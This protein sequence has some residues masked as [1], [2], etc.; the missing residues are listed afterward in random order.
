MNNNSISTLVFVDSNVAESQTFIDAVNPN[1]EVILLDANR[2]GIEQI[3]EILANYNNLDSIQIV[4]HGDTAS[5]QLG[6]SSLNSNNFSSYQDRLSQWGDALTENGDL[7]LLGCNVAEGE[8][9]RSFINRLSE[10]TQADIAASEDLTGNS[11]LDGDWILEATTGSIEAPSAFQVEAIANYQGTLANVSEVEANNSISNPQYISASSFTNESNGD[12]QNSSGNNISQTYDHASVIGTG[13]GTFDYYSFSANAGKEFIFDIDNNNFDTELFLYDTNGNLIKNNDDSI[14]TGHSG[15]DRASFITHTFASAGTY[16]IGVAKY[17]SS[18]DSGGITG[19]TPSGGDSY[20]LNISSSQVPTFTVTNNNDSGPGSLRQAI[21]DAENNNNG[22][23]KDII[24]LSSLSS[25]DEDTIR[26]NSSLPIIEESVEIRGDGVQIWGRDTHQIFTVDGENND[27]QINLIGFRAVGGRAKGGDGYTGGG[28]GLGAGGALF[29]NQGRVVVDNV[30]FDYNGAI[31]GNSDWSYNGGFTESDGSA[32]GSG[33]RFNVNSSSTSISDVYSFD[34][35]PFFGGF[36][37]FGGTRNGDDGNPGGNGFGGSFGVGGGAGG[38]GGGAFD[39]IAAYDPE[40]RG[41]DGGNGGIGG[42]GAGGGAGGGGGRDYDFYSGDE[43]GNGGSGASGGTHGGSGTQGFNTRNTGTGGGGA[44]LG[45]AIFVNSDADLVL[46]NSSFE[47]NFVTGG[48]G[49]NFSSALGGN[50]Y[51]RDGATVSKFNTS[52]NNSYG[53]ISNFPLPNVSIQINSNKT[54]LAESSS[55]SSSFTI[56]LDK[57]FPLDLI[58]NYELSGTATNGTD[59]SNLSGSTTIPAGITSASIDLNVINDTNLEAP[60]TIV[61]TLKNGDNYNFNNSSVNY[62]ITDDDSISLTGT[63]NATEGSKNGLF[64][65]DWDGTAPSNSNLKFKITG[66]TADPK[67]DYR[68]LDPNSEDKALSPN[69]DGNYVLDISNESSVTVK[70]DA[71]GVVNGIP[72]YDDNIADPNETVEITL[73]QKVTLNSSERDIDS[74]TATVSIIDNDEP[75]II[76]LSTETSPQESEEKTGIFNLDLSSEVLANGEPASGA[77]V[78]YSISDTADNPEDYSLFLNIDGTRS[79]LSSTSG[80]FEIPIGKDASSSITIEVEPNDDKIADPNET[81]TLNLSSGSGY[82]LG[83]TTSATLTIQDDDIIPNATISSNSV[84]AEEGGVLNFTVNLDNPALAGGASVNYTVAGTA[85]EGTDFD[86]LN[87]TVTILEGEIEATVSIATTEDF[88]AEGTET[89]AISLDSG[90]GYN[91]TISDRSVTLDITDNDT[92]G[93]TITPERDNTSEAGGQAVFNAV[94]TSEPTAD[95]NLNLVSDDTTEGTVNTSSLVFNSNNWN[96]AQS[97]T[98]TGADDTEDDGDT[99]YNVTT[100]GVSSD[101]NYNGINVADVPLINIDND[102]FGV[103]VTAS[104][105]STNTSEAGTIDSY[106]IALSKTPGG[107]VEI[108]ITADGETQVSTDGVNFSNS[109]VVTLGDTT[110][111]TITVKATDDSVVEGTHSSTISHQISG[112]VIDSRYGTDLAIADITVQISDN[113]FPTVNI[114][115]TNDANEENLVAGQYNLVLSDPTPTEITVNYEVNNSSTAG[116][117]DYQPLSG[118]VSIPQGGTSATIN[119]IPT[120]DSIAETAETVVINLTGGTGYEL[121]ATTIGT[122]AIDDDDFAEVLITESGSQ[123]ELREGKT[124]DTYTLKLNSQPISDVTIS[125]AT[126]TNQINSI[127]SVT[128]TPDDWQTEQTV[129]VTSVDDN[130]V[131]GDRSSNIAHTATSSDANYDGIA[132]NSV[133]A[134]ITENDVAGIVVTNANNL[135]VT[136]GDTVSYSIAL[137]TQPLADVTLSFGTSNDLQS[138]TPLTFTPSNWNRSQTVTLSA[139]IDNEVESTEIQNITHSLTST[140]AVYNGLAVEDVA[141]AINEFTFDPTETA[142]GL[143][144]SLDSMQDSIDAQFTSIELP[145]I[146]SLDNLAP[147]LIGN[148]KNTLINAIQTAGSLDSDA[149]A[150]LIESKIESALGLDV[151]VNTDLSADE[152]TFDLTIAKEYNLASIGLDA[153][154]GL[155]GLGIEVE[156]SADLTF[157]YEFGLGFGISQEFGFFVDTDKTGFEA[158]VS[159][160]LSDN[161]NAKGSLGFLAIDIEND[162]DSPTAASVTFELGINDTDNSQGIKIFDANGDRQLDDNEPN[163]NVATNGTSDDLTPQANDPLDTNNNGAYDEEQFNRNEGVYDT[164]T[165]KISGTRRDVYFFDRDRDGRLDTAEPFIVYNDNNSNDR[166]DDGELSNTQVDNNNQFKLKKTTT[167]SPKLYFDK[168]NNN[169]LDAA[170]EVDRKFDKNNDLLLNPDENIAGE[171]AFEQGLGIAYLDQNNNGQLDS[172]EPFVNSAFDALSVDEEKVLNILTDS[173]SGTTYIDLDGDG[174]LGDDDPEADSSDADTTFLDLNDNQEYDEDDIDVVTDE[175]TGERFLDFDG[176]NFADD[177]ELKSDSEDDP[178]ELDDDVISTTTV[179]GEEISYLDKDLQPGLSDDD[180]KILIVDGVR[181]L[182]LDGDGEAGDSEPQAK[183]NNDFSELDRTQPGTYVEVLDDGDRL[184]LSEIGNSSLG[185]LFDISLAANANLGLSA[186]TSIE[187]DTAF[188]SIAFDLAGEFP[189]LSYEDGEVTGPQKPTIAFNDVELDLGSFLTDFAKPV[190][191][192]VNEIIDPF[193]PIVEF[194]N[195]DTKLLSEIGIDSLFD[196]N[197]DGKVNVLELAIKIAEL[198][199]KKPNA[200]YIKFFDSVVEISEL[201]ENLNALAE[202]GDNIIIDLGSYELGSSFDPSDS[203]ADATTAETDTTESAPSLDRQLNSSPTT[204]AKTTQKNITKNLTASGG[205]FEIPLLTNPSTAIDLLLGKDVPLFTYDMPALEVGFEIEKTFPIWGPIGGL[206]EGNFNVAVDL[207]FGFDTYGFR[208]WQEVTDFEPLESYRVLDGFY[209]SDRENADG[210]GADVDELTASATIAAGAGIDVKVVSG[211]VKGGLE[212][213]IGIDLVDGGEVNGSDDGRLRASEVIDRIATPWELFQLSGQVNAF[214]AAEVKAGLTT[215][216]EKRFATFQLAE[217]SVGPKG[218]SAS[219][220]FDGTIAGGKVFFDADFDLEHDASEP[221]T[222]TSAD[223]S[224]DLEIPLYQYDLNTNGEIDPDEGKVVIVDG[225][226]TSTGLP[227]TAPIITT[228]DATVATPLTSLAT[229]VAEPDFAASQTEVIDRFSLAANTNL[230]NYEATSADLGLFVTQTKLQNLLILATQKISTTAFIGETINGNNVLAQNGSIYLDNNN[231]QQL[232]EDDLEISLTEEGAR[233]FDL[234]GNEALDNGELSSPI[235]EADIATAII[236][237]IVTRVNNGTTPN[238]NDT[239]T[240]E[241]IISEA[242]TSP[243]VKDANTTLDAA[244]I[245]ALAAIIIEKN[246]TID[247]ILNS[248]FLSETQQRQQI[249]SQWTFID[250][251]NNEALDSSEPYSLVNDDGTNDLDITPFDANNN[252]ELDRRVTVTGNSPEWVFFDSNANGTFDESEPFSVVR[253]SGD[254]DLEID[255]LD[256]NDNGVQDNNEPFVITNTFGTTQIPITSFDTNTD[257]VL[258]PDE[259]ANIIVDGTALTQWSYVDSNNNGEFDR[260]EL[261]SVIYNDGSDELDPYVEGR[262]IFVEGAESP[263]LAAGFQH[264][265]INPLGTVARLLARSVGTATAQQEVKDALGLPNVDLLD[266]NPLNAIKNNDPNGL[267]IYS[268][269]VQVQNTLVQLEALGAS[270]QEVIDSI[271]QKIDNN[272]AIDFSDSTQVEEIIRE[273]VPAIASNAEQ[274][275]AQVITEANERIDNIVADTNSN[276][277][278]KATEITQVQT[279]AQGETTQDLEQ[280]GNGEKTVTDVV[281]ENT[282]TELTEQ[283]DNTEANDPTEVPDLNVSLPVAEADKAITDV[284]VPVTIDVLSNDSHPDDDTLSVSETIDANNGTVVVNP[285][286]TIT[287]TPD[288]GF[289]GEDFFFYSIEDSNENFDSTAVVVKVGINEIVIEPGGGRVTGSERRDDITG[290]SGRAILSGLGGADRFIYDSM[291]DRGDI[292]TDFT[293]AEDKIV[294]SDLLDNLNYTGENPIADSYIQFGS[295]GNDGIVLVDPDGTGS[296]SRA[297]TF[298]TVENI[299]IEELNNSDNFEF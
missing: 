229:E 126:D 165:T 257:G 107:N 59:Y 56:S 54:E 60:E 112:Q 293:V 268:K 267:E 84:T 5:L 275:A 248:S 230:Y 49:G 284:D 120:Q 70:V 32:G 25:S 18:G 237:T 259:R 218:T 58:V 129:T 297:Q 117:S 258:D 155:P 276:E 213:I 172:N 194:L 95:V 159:L 118:T 71:T 269:Q 116:A 204:G 35:S 73:N 109:L 169:R 97:F 273:V 262:Q 181:F 160:G 55:D 47:G 286:N 93:I 11:N 76:N 294:M 238:L 163:T 17:N 220:V 31:G 30:E 285:N 34:G 203:D 151:S 104:G 201:V 266:Y 110:A 92:A 167:G 96:T 282:G 292:L 1:T 298:L 132:I 256:S 244:A 243:I 83:T 239:A 253:P 57:S 86:S 22:S 226:D 241:A 69:G 175:D 134:N 50:I 221:F 299:S 85:T 141:V 195:K 209:V 43:H 7:L 236:D 200:K 157:D 186:V 210:T 75:P 265:A 234:N 252:G 124:T 20:T 102:G 136:E 182:D 168:N 65:F 150:G 24:D 251:N 72:N 190:I 149:L 148:F 179:D 202:G 188:P 232:D 161:F 29:I 114:V 15:T 131:T 217:F 290:N 103:L 137:A 231:N 63:T 16:I 178:L 223:G 205:S 53:T 222:F 36:G 272:E 27:T 278:E 9:G 246:N 164:T 143:A 66:G 99:S 10:V 21:L 156:G 108:T 199:G 263:A 111:Q 90:E 162:S 197:D 135:Q 128:F 216:W 68:L 208:Q 2:D 115:S 211:F 288:S 52:I 261:F 187:G 113:D 242:I 277:I 189:I 291:R 61:V 214:L 62:S 295:R 287:Y 105:G 77:M 88:I 130:R 51:V 74:V 79:S 39:G 106:A 80:L 250:T 42:F 158:E 94:L 37:G 219:S 166:L 289:T 139:I 127:S 225:V 192:T 13:D 142:G 38:G 196:K 152:A 227:Q 122:V 14:E 228:P 100:T 271:V 121:G 123:T 170:E 296:T 249:V 144:K 26:I 215:V 255:F 48:S 280:L 254:N 133:T 8:L 235:N 153:D 245:T 233:Y 78:N 171:G 145:F 206:V 176:D 19:T 270:E 184:T 140:D 46:L 193:R 173:D 40:D 12:I 45:G 23:T 3:T 33:G 125:F 81:V 260:D 41:G 264:L 6:N 207:A 146:G 64:T 212:G 281:N 180:A 91:T 82:V 28:G 147:D 174:E 101:S 4:S 185:D 283:I 154:L 240:V 224:Y 119:L 279:V 247:R 183:P 89:I 177:V 191:G 274:G 87:G 44:G 198:A 138:I 98:V 67:N